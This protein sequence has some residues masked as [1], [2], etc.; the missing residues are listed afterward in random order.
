MHLIKW[1]ERAPNS[2]T[3]MA[4][5]SSQNIDRCIIIGSSS[6]IAQKTNKKV[7]EAGSTLQRLR[8]FFFIIIIGIGEEIII[9]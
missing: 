5:N 7:K 6:S 2:L 9:Y 1:G 3:K 8:L 4:F